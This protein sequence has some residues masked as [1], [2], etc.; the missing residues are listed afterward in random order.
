[1]KKIFNI[2][3]LIAVSASLLCGCKGELVDTN[4]YAE[5]GVALNVY[6]PQPVMRGGELRFL[7]SNLDRVVEVIIPSDYRHQCGEGRRAFRNQDNCS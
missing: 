6:G 7:G 2:F 4:Q 3:S 5:A 1:M